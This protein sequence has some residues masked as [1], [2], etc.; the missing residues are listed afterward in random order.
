MTAR[1]G[2]R[3]AVIAAIGSLLAANALAS[4]ENVQKGGKM[5]ENTSSNGLP[6]TPANK[7]IGG[8]VGM[9]AYNLHPISQDLVFTNPANQWFYYFEIRSGL[10]LYP[11]QSYFCLDYATSQ[12]LLAGQGSITIFLNGYP[13]ASRVLPAPKGEVL[14]WIVPLPDKYF[15]LGF[16]EI[17]VSNR[18]KSSEAP[19][20]DVDNAANWIKLGKNTFLHLVRQDLTT[21]PLMSYPFP[22]LDPT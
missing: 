22:Y 14:P 17:R 4:S 12:T 2:A 15:K 8:P 20:R 11:K 18:Q 10:D 6:M 5:P 1:V 19:C 13:L 16:N 7:L 9:H 3:F 21:F